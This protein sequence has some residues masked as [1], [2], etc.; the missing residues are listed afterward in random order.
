MIKRLITENW[1][2]KLLC[3]V[4]AFGIWFA[5]HETMKRENTPSPYDPGIIRSMPD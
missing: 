1:L 4:L 5:V 2:P 3:L